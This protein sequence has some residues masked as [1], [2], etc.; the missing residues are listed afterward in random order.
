M[1]RIEII[2]LV[3]GVIGNLDTRPERLIDAW[4]LPKRGERGG[5]VEYFRAKEAFKDMQDLATD[6]TMKG[7]TPEWVDA[8]KAA[9]EDFNQVE[10]SAPDELFDLGDIN[11]LHGVLALRTILQETNTTDVNQGHLLGGP[12]EIISLLR[13]H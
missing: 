3:A 7:S 4:R 9:T 1:S 2:G 8:F 10:S 6:Q 11:V 13:R 12:K 5:R